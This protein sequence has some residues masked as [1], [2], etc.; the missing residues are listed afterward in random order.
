MKSWMEGDRIVFREDFE[1]LPMLITEEA[2]VSNLDWEVADIGGTAAA[3]D[4]VYGAEGGILLTPQDQ[5][6][7]DDIYLFPHLTSTQSLLTTLTW[8]TDNETIFEGVIVARTSV[9][10]SSFIMGMSLT[11]VEDYS[12][13]DDN[14]LIMYDDDD[15]SGMLQSNISVGGTD[16]CILHGVSTPDAIPLVGKPLHFRFEF[17]KDQMARIYL[18]GCFLQQASFLDNRVDLIPFIGI[19][20]DD[21]ASTATLGCRWLA[22][23]RV[24]R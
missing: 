20:S 22:L 10:T 15:N 4:C 3:T 12:T 19:R 23:S 7:N 9:A 2:I 1:Q 5:T 11:K 14:V 13:D 8:G 18:N 17:D 21:N 6:T 16:E 24:L